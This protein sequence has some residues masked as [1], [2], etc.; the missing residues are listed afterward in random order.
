MTSE[1]GGAAGATQQ[2]HGRGLRA[3]QSSPVLHL[4]VDEE[5]GDR[6][7]FPHAAATT[8]PS[9]LTCTRGMWPSVLS[10]NVS[11]KPAFSL[12]PVPEASFKDATPQV[13]EFYEE[14]NQQIQSYERLL[15]RTNALSHLTVEPG[16]G[17]SDQPMEGELT[18]GEKEAAY[19]RAVRISFICNVCLLIAKVA[20][21]VLTGSLSI[22]ASMVDSAL[23]IFSGF[24]LWLVGR[25]KKRTKKEWYKYPVGKDRVEPLGVIIFACVMGTASLNL[26]QESIIRLAQNDQ[27]SVFDYIGLGILLGTIVTKFC[28][29]SYCKR[30]PESLSVSAYRD[31]HRNDVVQNLFLSISYFLTQYA[32]WLDATGS[33][34]ISIWIIWNWSQT[35]IEQT[36]RLMGRSADPSLLQKLTFIAMH[37][38][39]RILQ[40]DTVRAFSVGQN[41]FVEVDVVLP[42]EMSLRESHDIGENLQ[43]LIEAQEEVDRCWVHLDYEADHLPEHKI[44]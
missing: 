43:I 2:R 11:T 28:L 6:T 23:D 41:Y 20:A 12:D 21:A 34:A 5:E 26:V 7:R 25:L 33:L 13:R 10:P 3:T 22:I 14:Q 24:V 36:K 15:H 39:E 4:E 18:G 1:G 16:V 19:K 9:P 44:L 35:L 37:F 8:T 31:D 32:W 29:W 38:D 40:V 42:E 17:M 30:Y 27:E